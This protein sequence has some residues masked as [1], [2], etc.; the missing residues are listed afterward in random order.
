LAFIGDRTV[1]EPQVVSE[2]ASPVLR[3]GR[4]R[5]SDPVAEHDWWMMPRSGVESRDQKSEIGDQG[6]KAK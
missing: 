2:K 1:R 3:D 4:W 5:Y 6:S